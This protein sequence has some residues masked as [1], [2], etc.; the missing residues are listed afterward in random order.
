MQ[1]VKMKK[2]VE[3]Y[4][5]SYKKS[6]ITLEELESIF[7]G[8]RIDPT[9]FAEILLELEQ[10]GILEAVRSAG[11]TTRR[12]SLA[13]GYRIYK[14]KLATDH[15][16][17]LQ[18][19]RLTI[20]PAIQLDS[21][22]ARPEAEFIQDKPWIDLIDTYLRLKGLP[23]TDAPAP[24]R[25]YQLTGNEKWITDLGG[26]TLLRRLGLWDQLRIHP[27]ADPLMMAVNPVAHTETVESP[28][29]CATN[30]EIAIREFTVGKKSICEADQ[31]DPIYSDMIRGS[32]M[33]AQVKATHLIVENKTTFQ[34]L[35][36]ILY[37]SDCHTLIYGCG[38]KITG[39]IEMF[40]L[41]YPLVN[42]EHHFYYFGDLDYEGIRIWYDT[43]RQQ[44]MQPALPFYQA[45]LSYP[46]ASG[47]TNQ[48]KDEEALEEFLAYFTQ[49]EQEI[50]RVSL[51]NGKYYP[52]E[53]LSTAQLQHIWRSSQWTQW[54]AMN[55]KR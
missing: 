55:W 37:E 1:K 52:Q 51:D 26:H 39:N 50:I 40:S 3:R 12:P 17:R 35:L 14:H 54:I 6:M 9:D 13:Y 31:S 2:K 7:V 53:I 28:G 16:H 47:K 45:C 23:V 22:Y 27:A 46:P 18:Q 38:N 21:Y 19:Y 41:Q 10:A 32:V 5:E 42:A 11:R 49:K 8:V 43:H 36:P 29:T 48:R 4:V 44:P 33:G 34:A 24:E 30:R 15:H 20:H 25:S